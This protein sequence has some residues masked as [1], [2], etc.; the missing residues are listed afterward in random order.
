MLSSQPVLQA[1]P[2]VL[3]AAGAVKLILLWPFR[4]DTGT[5][6]EVRGTILL[7]S[8]RMLAGGRLSSWQHSTTGNPLLLGCLLLV[9][10]WMHFLMLVLELPRLDSLIGSSRISNAF[11]RSYAFLTES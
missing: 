7:K 2:W 6:Q 5:K 3:K 1:H 10:G 11:F 8:L 4:C 9:A